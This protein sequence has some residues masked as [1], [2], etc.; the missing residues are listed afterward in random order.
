MAANVGNT[1]T[2]RRLLFVF[3]AN[4]GMWG[5]VVDSSRKLLNI[6]GC[7]LC[8]ITHGIAGEKS[9]WKECKAELGA[10]VEYVHKDELHGPLAAVATELPCIAAEAD[11]RFVLLVSRDAIARCKGSIADLRG[12]IRFHAGRYGLS[13]G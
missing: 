11:G 3:D 12:K 2:V 7:A 13:L 9:G 8:S 1:S 10:P 4:S 5:A 6:Q